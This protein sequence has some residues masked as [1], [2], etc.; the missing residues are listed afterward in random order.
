MIEWKKIDINDKEV[1]EKIGENKEGIAMFGFNSL[2]LWREYFDTSYCII[3]NNIVVKG[4]TQSEREILYF[5]H[6]INGNT[7]ALFNVLEDNYDKLPEFSPLTE[8]NV[9]IILSRYPASQVKEIS[10]KFEYVY[11]MDDLANLAG[12]KYHAKRNHI[13]KFNG[14][15][16]YEYIQI[17][18]SNI[19]VLR[20][21]TA[22]MFNLIDKSPKEE[23]SAIC[24]AIDNFGKLEM[25]ACVI[26]SE[27]E[28]VA[29]SIGSLINKDVA[30]I[31]FEKADRNFEG[32]Y[33]LV[34]NLFVKRAFSDVLFINREEDL[35]IEGLRK[36]KL[37]Y[38][39]CKLNQMYSIRV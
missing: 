21:A 13:S 4:V 29:Y 18:M 9:D 12:K 37:S 8:K 35:G 33:A 5:P 20:D 11:N 28:F 10:G 30:D 7:D 14:K 16:D 1:F 25:R 19:G 34:N 2:Y 3:E 15:Y 32:S 38:Y 22:H 23:Y 27:G 24:N 36:A 6:G 26:V 39:P 17:D 31:H